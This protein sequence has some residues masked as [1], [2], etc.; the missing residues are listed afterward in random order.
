MHVVRVNES[1]DFLSQFAD[2]G[3]HPAPEGAPLQLAEP[4][5]DGVEPGR[6]GR[7]EMQVKA[8]MGSQEVPNRFGRM[9]AGVVDD[10]VQ[11]QLRRRGAV[12]LREQLAEFGSAMA[13]GDAAE[14]LAGGHVEGSIQIRGPVSLVVVR[15]RS[16]AAR[17]HRQS[18]LRAVERLDLRL[19]VDREHQRVVGR[20]EVEPDHVDDLLGKLRVPA[21]LE[22]LEPMRLDVGRP[23]DLPHLPL[24]DP[25]VARHQPRAPVGRLDGHPLGGQKQNALDGARGDDRRPPRA[26]AIEQAGESFGAVAA[27]PQVHGRPADVQQSSSICGTAAL[28]ERQQDA[29][30]PRL[31]ARRRRTPQPSAQ[32]LPVVGEQLKALGCL[33]ASDSTKFH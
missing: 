7:R 25:R 3:E 1:T 11:G 5:F 6:A 14:H 18:R 24:R 10:Q 9:R 13:P 20:V 17:F 28:V 23:P 33:H 4:G 12:D 29:R 19:L 16:G 22:G 31:T 15:Q 27:V 26:R 8:G 2:A 21:E 30:S 32:G